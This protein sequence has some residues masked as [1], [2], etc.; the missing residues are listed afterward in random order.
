MTSREAPAGQIATVKAPGAVL[1][2]LVLAKTPCPGQSKTRLAP[3][4]GLEGAAELAAAAL[5]DTLDVV[6]ATPAARGVLVLA[7]DRLPP[8]PP[9]IEVVPQ[10]VGSHAERIAVALAHAPGPALLIGMDT[11]QVTADL[12][13]IDL[14]DPWP[15][16]W[17]GLAEDGGWW[18]LG[19]RA[20][21]RYAHRVLAGVPM[22]T[23]ETGAIQRNRLLAAGLAVA[24]LPVL[25]DVDEPAD[26]RA[27]AAHAPD[28]RFARLVAALAGAGGRGGDGGTGGDGGGGGNV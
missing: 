20:P 1:T 11:P 23:P 24:D 7:G 4:F 15:Q 26:A 6:A 5:A 28:T 2:I 13:A 3:E 10:V 16:A 12:L 18:A 9:G 17:I 25:R 8:L 22:S 19:L 21:A 27:V 14:A